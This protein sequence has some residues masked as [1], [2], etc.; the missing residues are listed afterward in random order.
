MIGFEL[1][2]WVQPAPDAAALLEQGQRAR[3]AGRMDEAIAALEPAA[4]MRPDDVDVLLELGLAYYGAER[5]AEADRTLEAAH[6]L[7]P[8]YRDVTLARAR[9]ALAR[10]RPGQ[11]RDL[12]E[13]LAAGG[14]AE[15]VAIRDQATAQGRARLERLDVWAT[16]STLET[17]D[18]WTSFGVGVGGRIAP[19]WSGW[20]NAE[21]TRRF[22]LV[23]VY[24]EVGVEHGVSGGSVWVSVGGAPDAD[25]RAELSVATGTRIEL[26]DN[27]LAAVGDVRFSRYPVGEIWT[28]RPGVIWETE[29]W[30]GEAR[31]IHLEDETGTG[32]DGWMV[33]GDVAVFGPAT[34]VD[35]S[36]SDAPETA[37]GFTVDVRS[38]G[39]GVR[40]DFAE[41]LWVRLGFVHEDR[42]LFGNRD[43]VAVSL[44]RRF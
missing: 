12:A 42:G 2:A 6:R 13:P 4:R 11:A 23:D 15:A 18:D 44:T 7:A 26:G 10:G 22:G 34:W 29:N 25:Y 41:G 16:H 33:R 27:G 36:A 32:R 40:H 17:Q 28:I 21:H 24:G 43:E 5:L 3:R 14:D 38:W 9:V 30:I 19:G 35:A 1:A 31:W 8:A 39:V 20:A 37:D